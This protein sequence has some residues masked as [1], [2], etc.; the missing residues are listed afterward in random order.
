[1]RRVFRRRFEQAGQHGGFRQRNVT[2]VLAEVEL[3]GRLHAERAAAHISAVEIEFQDLA[4]G[5]MRLEPHGQKRFLDLALD[6][7]LVRQEQVFGELLRNGRTALHHAR[8]A[9]VDRQRTEEPDRIDAQMVPEAAVLGGERGLDQIVRK[10]LERH[11]IVVLDAAPADLLPVPVEEGDGEILLFQPIVVGRL[12]EGRH[13]E[14]EQHDGAAEAERQPLAGELDEDATDAT[15]VEPVHES[16]ERVEPGAG[17][18]AGVVD[19]R[20]HPGVERQQR[21]GQAPA[22]SR[23]P[24]IVQHGSPLWTGDAE[25]P[26][27]KADRAAIA[28]PESPG[29]LARGKPQNRAAR[30]LFRLATRIVGSYGPEAPDAPW[31]IRLMTRS[32]ASP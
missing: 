27:T 13:G 32:G 30:E 25:R 21:P 11:G 24:E 17:P 26:S 29:A 28:E 1:M 22:E 5:Q 15:D 20:I 3:G 19:R 12:A 10:L 8:R 4:L 18:L 7:A 6:G 2:D 14:A 31:S 9:R 23:R 16:A